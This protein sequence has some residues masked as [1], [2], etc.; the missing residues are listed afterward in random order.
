MELSY[1]GSQVLRQSAEPVH[2]VSAEIKKLVDQMFEAMRENNGIGLAAPQVGLN[3]RVLVVDL[4]HLQI[5]PFALINPVIA[6][7][8]GPLETDEEGCLSIPG[9]FLP[10]TRHSRCVVKGRD[11]KGR[12]VTH[13]ADGLLSRCLQHE[14]DH[15]EGKLFVDRVEDAVALGEEIEALQKRLAAYALKGDKRLLFPEA[16]KDQEKAI[17]V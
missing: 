7:R 16:G 3:K 4:S 15:L 8:F 17:A 2:K 11:I 10:V 9:V 13:E 1:Y 12:M 14:I 5:E 6:R